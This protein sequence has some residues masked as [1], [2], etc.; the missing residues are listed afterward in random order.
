MRFHILLMSSMK[1]VQ[2]SGQNLQ[3]VCY[4][5]RHLNHFGHFESKISIFFVEIEETVQIVLA[6]FYRADL[7]Q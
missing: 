7:N 4:I 1:F 3:R 2:Q 5:Q 6:Y